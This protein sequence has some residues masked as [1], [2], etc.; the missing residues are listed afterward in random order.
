VIRRKMLAMNLLLTVI[1]LLAGS[2]TATAAVAAQGTGPDD[3][4]VPSSEWQPLNVGDSYWYAF[5]YAGDGSQIQVRLEVE[6]A[7]S[8]GFQV[9]TPGEIERWRLGLEANPIGR[10]SVDPS[11]AKVLVWSGNFNEVGIY[12]VVVEHAGNQPGTSYYLLTISGDGVSLPTST[13]T[14][15]ATPEPTQPKAEPKSVAPSEP[16]GKLVFQTS[17]GGNIYTINVDGSGLQRITDGMDPVWS[18]DGEQIAFIRWRDPRGVWVIDADGSGARR[19][20]DWSEARY[21]SWAPDG[22]QIV[23]TRQAGGTEEREFCF[24]GRCFTIPARTFWKLGIVDPGDGSFVE[25]LPNSDVSQT[26]DWSPAGDQIA[27][28]AVHGLMVQSVDGTVSYQITDAANDTHP[29]WSPDGSKVA[30]TRRQHDHWE[31]Y[32]VDV[33]NGADADGG[34]VRRLTNTPQ[35]ANGEV[36]SSAAPAWSPDGNYIAFLTDRAASATAGG[37]WEIWV[38]RADGSGQQP[39]FGSELDGIALDYASLGERA[40]SWTE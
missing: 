39:M 37:Q 19:V 14:P 32:V 6:P 5:E 25:P 11:A 4:L 33:S 18:P 38:M 34:N 16:T 8:A 10:G 15:T 30:F 12:Y 26:P 20:F 1:V 24:R 27:F 2:I 22:E 13:P 3:A 29:V 23:F 17:M 35:K 28:D 21:P 36:A 9:W 40:I 31:I 7:E